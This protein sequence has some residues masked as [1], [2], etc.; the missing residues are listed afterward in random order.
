MIICGLCANFRLSVDDKYFFTQTRTEDATTV[1]L[2][3]KCSK[4]GLVHETFVGCDDYE[5]TKSFYCARLECYI[6]TTIC[7]ANQ[8]QCKDECEECVQGELVIE[9]MRG[10]Q[11]Y[12]LK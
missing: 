2:F 12:E 11:C 5:P 8:T 10:V 9:A 1:A 4:H 7:L 6:G 3:K